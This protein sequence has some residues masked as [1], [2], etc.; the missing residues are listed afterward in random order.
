MKNLAKD[1]VEQRRIYEPP[2][3]RKEGEKFTV[4]DGNRRVACLKLLNN[5]S[6]SPTKEWKDFFVELSTKGHGSIP[7]K[8]DCQIEDDREVIDEILYRRH[9]GSQSGIGQMS[10]DEP[11]KTIFVN[12]TGKDFRLNLAEQIEKILK[13]SGMLDAATRVPRSNLNRLLSSEYLRNRVGIAVSG[14]TVELT[15]KEE[16]V[17]GAL[18][19]IVDDLVTKEIVL[20]DIWANK[21]K[22]AYLNALDKEGVLPTVHDISPARIKPASGKSKEAKPSPSAP[23]NPTQRSALIPKIE[24]NL[25]DV[26][27]LKRIQYI[28]HELQYE[29]EFESHINAI[30]VLFRV[31]LELSLEYYI[32]NQNVSVHDNDNLKNRFSKVKADLLANDRIDKKYAETLSKFDKTEPMLSAHTMNQFIHSPK[33]FPSSEH[34]RPMWDSLESFILGCL[35]S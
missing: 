16:K 7:R 6:H 25:P 20:G 33:F 3:V 30:A 34:L 22:Q 4:Y 12:R 10:W 35:K 21:D 24:Y 19:R 27:E 28:W 1:I 9:T 29:L 15:H 17:L 32:S 23:G 26:P 8:I 14:K 11:A 2:L 13:S 31:L 5:P 18:K